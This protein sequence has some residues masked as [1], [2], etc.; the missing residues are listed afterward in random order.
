MHIDYAATDPAP[1]VTT[2]GPREY[3]VPAPEVLPYIPQQQAQPAPQVEDLAPHVEEPV[4]PIEV[5][6]E[7]IPHGAH[8]SIPE[9]I[10][11]EEVPLIPEV[12]DPIPQAQSAPHV[13][14][15]VPLEEVPNVPDVEY[16][17][18][19]APDPL[20]EVVDPIPQ[21]QPAPHVEDPAPHVEVPKEVDVEYIPHGA[22]DPVPDVVDPVDQAPEVVDPIPQAQPAPHVEEPAPLVDVPNV[23]DVEYI[24]HGA[25][26]P[27]PDVV[28]P[29]DYIPRVY[30][31]DPLP[32][33]EDV[34]PPPAPFQ[35]PPLPAIVEEATVSVYTHVQA[36]GDSPDSFP[37][38][39]TFTFVVKECQGFT[40]FFVGDEMVAS[41]LLVS[42]IFYT[43]NGNIDV[44]KL[45][46]AHLDAIQTPVSSN[47][48]YE[49]SK[50]QRV[51]DVAVQSVSASTTVETG[52]SV[53]EYG[54]NATSEFQ[55]KR[56]VDADGEVRDIEHTIVST[57]SA[58][59]D[60]TENGVYTI[61]GS[62]KTIRTTETFANS[63]M[64]DV[65]DEYTSVQMP[66]AG[67]R[68]LRPVPQTRRKLLDS[69]D[70]QY[71]NGIRFRD[72][73]ITAGVGY[74]TSL[75]GIPI[76]LEVAASV[77][78]EDTF[79]LGFDIF[80]KTHILYGTVFEK[81]LEKNAAAVKLLDQPL[82]NIPAI[83]LFTIGILSLEFKPELK[84]IAHAN[85]VIDFKQMFFEISVG[86]KASGAL[87][88]STPCFFVIKFSLGIQVIGKVFENGIAIGVFSKDPSQLLFS[89]QVCTELRH[90]RHAFELVVRPSCEIC[91]GWFCGRCRPCLQGL[92]DKLTYINIFG[93]PGHETLASTCT[94]SFAFAV[95]PPPPPLPPP[96]PPLTPPR[97]PSLLPILDEASLCS[98]P[99]PYAPACAAPCAKWGPCRAYGNVDE[100]Y[101]F[102]AHRGQDIVCEPC[103]EMCDSPKPI[104]D[105]VPQAVQVSSSPPPLQPPLQ[106]PLAPDVVP[107][108]VGPVH[109]EPILEPASELPT[110]TPVESNPTSIATAN[111][112]KNP[113]PSPALPP[114]SPPPPA[115]STPESPKKTE[116]TP[117][118]PTPT[119]TPPMMPPPPSPLPPVPAPTIPTTIPPTTPMSPVPKD[120]LDVVQENQYV[121]IFIPGLRVDVPTV[122]RS[123]LTASQSMD[124]LMNTMSECV[125]NVTTTNHYEVTTENIIDM[126]AISS[127]ITEVQ[128]FPNGTYITLHVSEATTRFTTILKRI[129]STES[130]TECVCTTQTCQPTVS[131]G[132]T[133]KKRA[134][135][136]LNVVW[137]VLPACVIIV[138]FAYYAKKRKRQPVVNEAPRSKTAFVVDFQTL[139]LEP[140]KLYAQV[141]NPIFSVVAQP[142]RQDEHIL[143]IIPPDDE[144]EP[145]V[146][147][148][149]PS[150]GG[151][152]EGVAKTS[153]VHINPLLED[154]DDDE[155]TFDENTILHQIASLKKVHRASINQSGSLIAKL[156]AVRRWNLVKTAIKN[157]TLT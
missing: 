53:P 117:I 101:K 63:G 156:R 71:P 125:T 41:G 23:P 17:P 88:V 154:V 26:D 33:I 95:Q 80:Y 124:D 9:V 136:S 14:E 43:D 67:D 115:P 57:F 52:V 143:E 75:F 66:L 151:D 126:T 7:Y 20:P 73:S 61:Y 21:A 138:G 64:P 18:H 65:S 87:Q 82:L 120:A 68:R 48:L 132:V 127:E 97:A 77:N 129:V 89:G 146:E 78:G 12:V 113:P 122:R 42:N 130:F 6:K 51:F 19:G 118:T 32:E 27:V 139:F 46:E 145:Y 16:I 142:Q 72:K 98:Y 81:K 54:T 60:D 116:S 106:P 5:Q 58:S 102:C 93:M 135:T 119:P 11:N 47:G 99:L 140:E 62:M 79:S 96:K 108:L 137:T 85:V 152:Q 141:T 36:F 90:I 24:P 157:N 55:T 121:T 35:P 40:S 150:Y 149:N 13:E 94:D 110:L 128:V 123:L 155:D 10:P 56:R 109:R 83:T 39:Q 4:P 131:L 69:W 30:A 45:V 134:D 147:M 84:L 100:E 153:G 1:H 112:T 103:F 148:Y 2:P 29:V 34:S 3:Y 76:E 144:H 31:V 37:D 50:S 104:P 105:P 91:T 38:D 114:T 44:V 49:E 86:L 111:P 92:F 107:V 22:H 70:V 74:Y 25:H 15:P 59:A 133:D 8:D 28:D